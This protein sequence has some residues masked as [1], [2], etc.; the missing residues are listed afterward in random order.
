[1]LKLGHATS[2]AKAE[3]REDH[4][5]NNDR[6]DYVDNAMHGRLLFADDAVFTWA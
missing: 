5:H 2:L 1:M 6:A 3:K 4:Q